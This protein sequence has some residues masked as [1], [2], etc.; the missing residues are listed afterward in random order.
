MKFLMPLLFLGLCWPCNA[1]FNTYV[2]Y[3]VGDKF[4]FSRANGTIC[5]APQYDKV[6]LFELNTALTPS[7]FARVYKSVNGKVYSSLIDTSGHL[8]LPFLFPKMD[9]VGDPENH[10]ISFYFSDLCSKS[11][12]TFSP[13]Q[14]YNLD[15][16]LSQYY[17]TNGLAHQN[18]IFVY[19]SL[20]R[21]SVYDTIQHK[22]LLPYFSSVAFY[23]FFNGTNYYFV[24]QGSNHTS[25]SA[26]IINDKGGVC[27]PPIYHQIYMLLPENIR[28]EKDI[29]MTEFIHLV[30][31]FKRLAV[32]RTAEDSNHLV[33]LYNLINKSKLSSKGFSHVEYFDTDKQGKILFLTQITQNGKTLSGLLDEEGKVVFDNKFKTFSISKTKNIKAIPF[34][35]TEKSE[36]AL[37]EPEEN[38]SAKNNETNGDDNLGLQYGESDHAIVP[39]PPQPKP[40]PNTPN[41]LQ[42]NEAQVVKVKSKIGLKLNDTV[43]LKPVYDSIVPYRWSTSAPV[44]HYIAYKKGEGYLYFLHQKTLLSYPF[45]TFLFDNVQGKNKPDRLWILKLKSNVKVIRESNL[46]VELEYDQ[47][48]YIKAKFFQYILI[49][50]TGQMSI[51]KGNENIVATIQT[52]SIF[53]ITPYD[54]KVIC[55]QNGKFTVLDFQGKPLTTFSNEKPFEIINLEKGLF[56]FKETNKIGIL[57]HHQNSKTEEYF[58]IDFDTMPT[59]NGITK[60]MQVY[61]YFLAPNNYYYVSY[62]EGLVYYKP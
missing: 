6:S 16:V 42:K 36:E 28:Y 19:D 10:L 56:K 31:L 17:A 5:I 40:T 45:T 61:R 58:F 37:M 12:F 8:Y 39:T 18:Q 50:Q 54:K 15:S 60:P 2:P 44:Q 21:K 27:I 14:K 46:A 49:A 25:G 26:G 32:F 29:S 24:S 7:Y 34:G 9:F 57:Y 48:R 13:A 1:Q 55:R 33:H 30:K 59:T 35:P 22:V 51:L 62:E 20:N 47:V 53:K 11:N 41:A 43:L 23:D 38:S 52:D 4:G 3:R